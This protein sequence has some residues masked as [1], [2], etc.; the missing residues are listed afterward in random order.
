MS[1]FISGEYIDRDHHIRSLQMLCAHPYKCYK[2][3]NTYHSITVCFASLN[4]YHRSIRAGINQNLQGRKWKWKLKWMLLCLSLEIII[5][6]WKL[7][8]GNELRKFLMVLYN[9]YRGGF[10]INFCLSVKTKERSLSKF[11]I[12][13]LLL[14]IAQ[15]FLW[16][17]TILLFY[18]QV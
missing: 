4:I 2:S 7:S 9:K 3:K 5:A 1:Q 14:I 17:A 8:L 15:C 16:L 12:N 10:S 13:F 6:S 11:S 18:H